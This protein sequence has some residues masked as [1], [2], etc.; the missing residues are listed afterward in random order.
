MD[1]LR[2]TFHFSGEK[3]RVL[4]ER[5]ISPS[6]GMNAQFHFVISWDLAEKEREQTQIKAGAPS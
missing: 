2:L 6:P 3:Q 1:C 4:Y 5:L